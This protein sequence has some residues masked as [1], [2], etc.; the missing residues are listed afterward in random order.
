MFFFGKKTIQLP[1]EFGEFPPYTGK[2]KKGPIILDRANY[3]R[4]IY[5]VKGNIETF[6]RQII[7]VGYS[8]RSE[9][10]F[11]RTHNSYII[12]EPY[13]SKYKIAYH[14]KK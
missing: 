6:K 12:V 3:K 2:I 4:V 8:Q 11:A 13:G 14:K 10:K 5:Y 7:M 1:L 9:V